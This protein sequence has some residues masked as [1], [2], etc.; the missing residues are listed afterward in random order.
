[1][2]GEVPDAEPVVRE[3]TGGERVRERLEGVGEERLKEEIVRLKKLVGKEH[4]DRKGKGREK[5]RGVGNGD[6]EK[7]WKTSANANA[8]VEDDEAKAPTLVRQWV[9]EQRS[10]HSSSLQSM[11]KPAS[12]LGDEAAGR[13]EGWG[14]DA[15]AKGGSVHTMRSGDAAGKTGT[16]N[17]DAWEDQGWGRQGGDGGVETAGGGWGG[18]ENVGGGTW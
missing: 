15:W 12:V 18:G 10:R 3:K 1:M 14:E 8:V 2:P 13:A 7:D 4:G 6:E 17:G 11:S 16:E 5:E 9:G